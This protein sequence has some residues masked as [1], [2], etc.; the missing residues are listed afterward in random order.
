[1]Q[2]GAA[3][4]LPPHPRTPKEPPLNSLGLPMGSSPQRWGCS[5]QTSPSPPQRPSLT[6]LSPPLFLSSAPQPHAPAGHGEVGTPPAWHGVR[7]RT[8]SVPVCPR[9]SPP[10]LGSAWEVPRGGS[11]TESSSRWQRGGGP[12]P[13]THRAKSC[14]PPAGV[15]RWGGGEGGGAEGAAPPAQ[16]LFFFYLLIKSWGCRGAWRQLLWGGDAQLGVG[17]QLMNV[18]EG[19]CPVNFGT[20]LLSPKSPLTPSHLPGVTD[21]PA[22]GSPQ[23]SPYHRVPMAEPCAPGDPKKFL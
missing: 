18:P 3:P 5:S 23:P 19:L 14:P 4:P 2:G 17:W 12:Q 15:R 21:P 13:C 16:G 9:V 1:M 7:C 22:P 10:S 11:R 8:L 6:L 20:A